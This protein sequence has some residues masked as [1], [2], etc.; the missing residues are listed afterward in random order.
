MNDGLFD[1]LEALPH[2]EIEDMVKQLDR[3]LRSLEEEF[4][5]LRQER[6]NQVEIIKSLRGAF[7]GIQE[8][9]SERRMLLSEFH[10][11]KKKAD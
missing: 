8:V 3:D 11:I 6:R 9:N 10:E 1:D 4:N 5:S 7:D 2:A